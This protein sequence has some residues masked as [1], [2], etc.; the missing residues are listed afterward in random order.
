[1]RPI[2]A[3]LTDFGTR[4]HYVGALKG[5]ILSIAPDAQVV[6]VLHEVAPHDV[7]EGAFALAA[8]Y[9]AFPPGTVFVAV[10]DP[11]VGSARRGI[12]VEAGGYRFVG[13]DNGLLTIV[14]A[15]HPS[16]RVHALENGRLWRPDVS[17]TFH[18]RDIFG[19]VAAHLAMGVVLDDVGPRIEDA[20][21]L[22]LSPVR[23]VG[24]DEW[25]GEV[26]HVDRFGNL[27]TTI[28][29]RALDAMLTASDDAGMVVRVADAVLPLVLT[30]ADVPP[31]DACALL[32]GSGRL[33]VAVNGGSAAVVLGAG[34]GAPVR[35]RRV[36][37]PGP[38]PAI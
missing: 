31:G 21:R 9:G 15:D 8:A 32:G 2:I 29:S 13:P 27:I 11:G 6:D 12:A 33:E 10:V 34:R 4:D 5:A 36:Y 3:L 19:P 22:P 7:E 14:L 26:V 16:A 20:C 28:T 35:V 30:Y 38:D 23:V 18:A 24:D 37:Q 1:M 25:E 17:A